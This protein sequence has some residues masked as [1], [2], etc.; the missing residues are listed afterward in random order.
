[1]VSRH[2]D[3]P[4]CAGLN[5]DCVC[6]CAVC[7]S[8]SAAEKLQGLPGSQAPLEVVVEY[9]LNRGIESTAME[10][11][12]LVAAVNS[13]MEGRRDERGWSQI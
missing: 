11:T 6:V 3:Y 8:G 9:V 5:T 4:L 13:I 12:L 10:S 1:M 7:V 2:G